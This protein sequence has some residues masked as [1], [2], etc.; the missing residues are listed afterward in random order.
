MVR[1]GSPCEVRELGKGETADRG[2]LLGEVGDLMLA[3]QEGG[4][5]R[6][7]H[8]EQPAFR[9]CRAVTRDCVPGSHR[10]CRM[11]RRL[12]LGGIARSILGV[13]DEVLGQ[14]RHLFSE[15]RHLSCPHLVLLARPVGGV[16]ST[17]RRRKGP[18]NRRQIES[19]HPRPVRIAD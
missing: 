12:P 13:T 17:G 1:R 18:T 14:A 6:T 11:A 10:V 5:P 8:A 2:D 15:L 9:C 7:R 16:G 3:G 4:E 19:R